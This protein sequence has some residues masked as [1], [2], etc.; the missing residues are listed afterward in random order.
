MFYKLKDKSLS[1]DDTFIDELGNT[2]FLNALDDEELRKLG[3]AK[4]HEDEQPQ[5]DPNL[6]E[7]AKNESYDEQNNVF[8]ISYSL[9][10][11]EKE[12]LLAFMKEYLNT[13]KML[14]KLSLNFKGK[15]FQNT[16]TSRNLITS[17]INAGASEVEFLSKDNEKVLLSQ[18]ELKELL[19]LCLK[20]NEEQVFEFRILKDKLEQKTE[21]ELIE[22]YEFYTHAKEL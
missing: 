14:E 9:K 21:Q 7:L 13:Q 12:K 1:Y 8:K 5:Y 4:V 20:Q 19:A 18:D 15:D 3:F 2:W 17:F 22:F 11:L 16:E 6:Y 10:P